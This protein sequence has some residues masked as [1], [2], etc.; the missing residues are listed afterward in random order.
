MLLA[1]ENIVDILIKK[2]DEIGLENYKEV[3]V[4]EE[5]VPQ[6]QKMD[7]SYLKD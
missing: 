1:T 3:E 4:P 5:L 6:L 2:E 7:E